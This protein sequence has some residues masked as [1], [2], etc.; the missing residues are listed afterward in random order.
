[1]AGAFKLLAM[2]QLGVANATVYDPG[3]TNQIGAGQQA[4]VTQIW[5]ANTD[6]VARAVTLNY[7][8]SGSTVLG[9]NQMVPGAS[10]NANEAVSILCDLPLSYGDTIQGLAAV[11][12]KVNVFLWG[13]AP[14]GK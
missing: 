7:V 13:E 4:R 11:A 8:P 9:S 1:M 6:T 10:M 3:G 2:V 12:S 14:T 5:I